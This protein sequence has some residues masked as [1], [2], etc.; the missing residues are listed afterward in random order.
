[1]IHEFGVYIGP[2]GRFVIEKP[3]LSLPSGEVVEC[4]DDSHVGTIVCPVGSLVGTVDAAIEVLRQVAR[5]TDFD[6]RKALLECTR[7][8][9]ATRMH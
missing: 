5:S 9:L 2:I 6:P 1:M 7:D 4:L 8:D 3:I